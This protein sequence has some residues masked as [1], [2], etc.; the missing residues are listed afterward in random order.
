LNDEKTKMPVIIK[1]ISNA[2]LKR[3]PGVFVRCLV[4]INRNKIDVRV[5]IPVEVK[6]RNKKKANF[7]TVS[8][9]YGS[10]LKTITIKAPSEIKKEEMIAKRY[11]FI[12]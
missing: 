10:T 11:L 6:S 7:V 4:L 2:R 8:L 9:V 5:I 12:D 1:E 3:V